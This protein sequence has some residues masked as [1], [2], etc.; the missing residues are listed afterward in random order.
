VNVCQEI[1]TRNFRYCNSDANKVSKSGGTL[2]IEYTHCFYN[3]S[4]SAYQKII[5]I[6]PCNSKLEHAKVGA[7]FSETQYIYRYIKFCITHKSKVT[8][9]CL[10]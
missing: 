7:F 2:K 5:K 4:D 3:Y 1:K 8:V 9:N 6:S 10:I